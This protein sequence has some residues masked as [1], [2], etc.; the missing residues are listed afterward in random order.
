MLL[1]VHYRIM[2]HL[3][4]LESTR[5]DRVALG[6]R[7]TQLWRFFHALQTSHVL[8]NS[9]IH[10]KAWTNIE[11]IWLIKGSGIITD[12][13]FVKV[14]WCNAPINGLPQDGGSGNPGKIWHFQVF[15]CQIRSPWVT[16]ITQISTPWEHKLYFL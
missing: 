10:A 12:V 3:G 1:A 11:P 7:L 6:Y 9:I 16:I 15:K 5:E 14:K 13:F 4:S 2:E 8:Y